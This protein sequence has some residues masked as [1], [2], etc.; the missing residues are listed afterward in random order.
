MVAQDC[1]KEVTLYCLFC[2]EK[3]AENER[4]IVQCPSCRASYRFIHNIE[5]CIKEAWID[6]C[7]EA[8]VCE[9]AD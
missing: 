2:R 8:C 7:G 1:G 3:M 9:R 4:H 6:Q 5:G